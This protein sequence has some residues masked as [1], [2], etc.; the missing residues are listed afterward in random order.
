MGEEEMIVA[1][2]A[3]ACGTGIVV[4]FLHT[5]KAAFLRRGQNEPASLVNEIRALR[6]EV[7]HVRQ[8]NNDVILSLDSQV[9][10]LDRRMDRLEDRSLA[11]APPEP[12]QSQAVGTRRG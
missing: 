10:T 12:S 6:E 1:I 11:S 7:Q 8:Q 3:I 4:T 5:I 9:R 2:V